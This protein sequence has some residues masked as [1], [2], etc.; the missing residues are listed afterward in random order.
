MPVI[1]AY[2]KKLEE[3]LKVRTVEQLQYTPELSKAD[4]KVLLTKSLNKI[5]LIKHAEGLWK[6]LNKHIEKNPA[7]LEE[8]WERLVHYW[9]GRIEWFAKTCAECYKE[10]IGVTS[11]EIQL[12]C[13]KHLPTGSAAGRKRNY[14]FSKLP[15]RTGIT[16]AGAH[17]TAAADRTPEHSK[18][19]N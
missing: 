15:S 9:I 14:S 2:W 12:M 5:T 6:R 13:D 1:T 8:V 10:N 4:L 18:T 11:P 19:G 3:T 16:A 17:A 7:L